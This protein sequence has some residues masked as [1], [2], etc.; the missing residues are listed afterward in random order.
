MSKKEKL[1]DIPAEIRP[2]LTRRRV[3]QAGAIGG[4]AAFVAAC[5]TGGSS[6]DSAAPATDDSANAD[7]ENKI[8]W[9]NW[10]YYMPIT[11]DG[12]FPDLEAFTSETGIEIET[13]GHVFHLN[14]SNSAGIIEN[15]FISNTTDSWG[16]GNYKLGFNISR[17]FN[18]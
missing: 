3:L 1:Q 13:G 2:F 4:A 11:E 17:V 10:P 5:G 12:K 8:V 7:G 6:S 9:A 14:V 18:F 16:D 15:D